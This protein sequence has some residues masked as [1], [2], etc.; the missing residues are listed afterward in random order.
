MR[1]GRSVI[2]SAIVSVGVA[3]AALAGT[4]APLAANAASVQVAAQAP[5]SVY[6]IYY[7][8]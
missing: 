6:W 3:G 8:L 7:H 2:I 4:V 1:I 5:A